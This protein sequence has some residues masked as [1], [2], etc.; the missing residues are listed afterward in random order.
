M[1]VSSKLPECNH[2]CVHMWVRARTQVQGPQGNMAAGVRIQASST[3]TCVTLAQSLMFLPLS[4][5]TYGVVISIVSMSQA[6]KVEEEEACETLCDPWHQANTEHHQDCQVCTER[7]QL[8]RDGCCNFSNNWYHLYLLII[9]EWI[10]N[11]L[12]IS[13]TW[14]GS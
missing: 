13:G 3:A 5:L 8:T 1:L 12:I 10:F 4:S 14:G 6:V 7:P 9:R 11:L 2:L